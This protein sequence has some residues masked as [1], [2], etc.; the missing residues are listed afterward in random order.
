MRRFNLIRTKDVSGVSGVGLIAEGI[1][2]SSG[3]VVLGWLGEHHTIE[4]LDSV[5]EVIDIHGHGGL[6]R[7]DWIDEED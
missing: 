3:K 5:Q 6:T 7:I 1:L 2:F 4:Q